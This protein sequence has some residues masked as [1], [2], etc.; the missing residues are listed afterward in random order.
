MRLLGLLAALMALGACS[1]PPADA[2]QM[3]LKDPNWDRVNVEVV[4]TKR[5]D[6]DSRAEGFITSREL[7]MRK[8]GS[9][10]VDVPNG[11]TLCWR[12]DRDPN[13]PVAGAWSGW[14]RA[15]L[16]PGQSAES[17]L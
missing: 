16:V 10:T 4:I 11:A 6:C 13:N 12:R 2:G 17:D 9:E 8:K 14:T 7:V 1:R 15:T 3:T 5:A